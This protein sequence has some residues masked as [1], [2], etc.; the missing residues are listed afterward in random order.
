MSLMQRDL[1]NNNIVIQCFKDVMTMRNF[2]MHVDISNS[3]L[4]NGFHGKHGF[5]M[6]GEVAQEEPGG[7][8]ARLRDH[9]HITYGRLW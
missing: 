3:W 9:D 5:G 2:T 6:H 1:I 7:R 4:D 8:I